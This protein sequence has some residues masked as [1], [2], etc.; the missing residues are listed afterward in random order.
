MQVQTLISNSNNFCYIDRFDD[1]TKLA[2]ALKAQIYYLDPIRNKV[3]GFYEESYSLVETDSPIKIN[4]PVFFA[5]SRIQKE[6]I[7]QYKTYFYEES[8]P[9]FLFPENRRGDFMNHNIGMIPPEQFDTAYRLIDIMTRKTLDDSFISFDPEKLFLVPNYIN[10]INKFEERIK[11]L[12]NPIVFEDMQ[13]NEVIMSVMNSKVSQGAK[14][15][16]LSANGKRY[17]FYVF[18]SLLGPITK[19]DKL[20]LIIRQDRFESNKFMITFRV[21]K[22]KTKLDIPELNSMTV[23]THAFILN[24]F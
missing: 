1:L 4:T 8:Y 7:N 3:F 23:D 15:L 24:L 22:K 21:F 13:D 17:G 19:A 5:G 20:T 14:L 16:T 11:L 9:Y 18:K 6:V 10:L 12:D 2:L